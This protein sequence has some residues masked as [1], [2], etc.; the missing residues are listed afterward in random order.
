M[1]EYEFSNSGKPS[2]DLDHPV[3]CRKSETPTN[4]LYVRTTNISG[5]QDLRLYD[6]GTFQLATVGQQANGGVL[7]ELHCIYEIVFYKPKLTSG[8]GLSV[9]TDHW[10]LTG[11]INASNPFGTTSTLQAGST[12]GTTLTSTTLTFPSFITDG[13][14]MLIWQV[15]GTSTNNIAPAITV[16]SAVTSLLLWNNDSQNAITIAPTDGVA[17]TV[18][19]IYTFKISGNGAV[20][21]FGTAGS[22][23]VVST[24][25]IWVQQF[26]GGISTLSNEE[27]TEEKFNEVEDEISELREKIREL[28]T[29]SDNEEINIKNR[30]EVDKIEQRFI[31]RML[32]KMNNNS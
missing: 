9:L 21:T 19:I 22:L 13:S 17:K 20:I 5:T 1:L 6:L 2:L 7:G 4:N 32:E 12:I 25:D 14:Y 15:N 24:G 30:M 8:I 28:K 29:E 11:T 10:K 26:N 3:E 16:S 18:Y 23:P 27:T 31:A